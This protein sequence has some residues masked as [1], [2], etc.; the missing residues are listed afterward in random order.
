MPKRQADVNCELCLGMGIIEIESW[1]QSP[2]QLSKNMH[3][4]F[5][6]AYSMVTKY[7]QLEML[8]EI[9]NLQKRISTA[10]VI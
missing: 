9:S 2:S 4:F 3:T 10:L 1:R 8:L 7:N 6:D 5:G